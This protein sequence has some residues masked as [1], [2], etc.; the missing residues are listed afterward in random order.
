MT[1]FTLSEMILYAM[2][3]VVLAVVGND[4]TI[5]L[6]DTSS[7]SL[8]EWLRI[9]P[10]GGRASQIEFSPDGKLLGVL[11]SSGTVVVIQNPR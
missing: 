1:R 2:A 8:L 9:G 5:G 7:G 11:M 10:V 4:V 3:V 6:L